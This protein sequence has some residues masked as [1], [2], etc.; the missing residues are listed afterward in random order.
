MLT[1]HPLY[2]SLAK[3]WQQRE[4]AYRELY[5]RDPHS[6]EVHQIRKAL[7]QELVPGRED[8][9]DRIEQMLNRQARPGVP[10]RPRIE[11]ESAHYSAV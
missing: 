9:K 8:F 2:L 10:G 7:D 11:D 4:Y 3:T 6:G 1:R 5:G